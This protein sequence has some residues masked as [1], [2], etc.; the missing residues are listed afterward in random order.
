M[1]DIYNKNTINKM[2]FY[3]DNKKEDLYKKKIITIEY[4]IETEI[5]ELDNTSFSI[6]CNILNHANFQLKNQELKD[7]NLIH[8]INVPLFESLTKSFLYKLKYLDNSEL[9][10]QPDFIVQDNSSYIIKNK[11]LTPDYN[12]IIHFNIIFPKIIGNKKTDILRKLFKINKPS[13]DD[14][15]NA[16][17]LNIQDI[18]DTNILYDKIHENNNINNFE[19]LI[20]NFNPGNL[21]KMF[22][23]K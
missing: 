14:I 8:N 4:C 5:L 1:E 11:G 6:N 17:K 22:F 15:N 12:L 7:Y 18:S 2:F 21:F 20:N 9:I 19:T 10:I 16:Q 3:R 13:D 23:N